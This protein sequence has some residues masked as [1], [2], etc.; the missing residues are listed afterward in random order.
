MSL[1]GRL[2]DA[3]ARLPPEEVLSWREIHEL[4]DAAALTL[5]WST[6]PSWTPEHRGAVAKA[7]GEWCIDRGNAEV[8]LREITM[9][10]PRVG[11]WLSAQ[12]ALSVT[13]HIADKDIHMAAI[14][15]A[16]GW[17]RGEVSEEAC[18]RAAEDARSLGARLSSNCTASEVAANA[19]ASAA[20]AAVDDGDERMRRN[21]AAS[22]CW[23][24]ATAH[25]SARGVSIDK[26]ASLIDWHGLYL[27]DLCEVLAVST[28]EA[29]DEAAIGY[30]AEQRLW[31]DYI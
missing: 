10:S 14:S 18:E 3:V 25:S 20:W 9:E 7:M 30:E 29:I 16:K 21:N 17:V 2:L 1:R 11:V 15:A 24:A 6:L 22:A 4:E 23:Y 19:A 31:V 27:R 8:A 12:V 5:E 28:R 13:K 26:V